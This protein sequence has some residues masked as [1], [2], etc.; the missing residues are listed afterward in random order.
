[1]KILFVNLLLMLAAMAAMV[2]GCHNPKIKKV[3]IKLPLYIAGLLL[4]VVAV[5][6]WAYCGLWW[7]INWILL[8]E[9]AGLIL[10]AVSAKRFKGTHNYSGTEPVILGIGIALI[11]IVSWVVLAIWG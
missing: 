8:A 11:A 3:S 1:M 9:V 2:W 4:E 10:W 5:I 6:S 7:W